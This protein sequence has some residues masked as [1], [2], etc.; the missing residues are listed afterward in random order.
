M[1][2]AHA[3]N[4]KRVRHESFSQD[5]ATLLTIIHGDVSVLYTADIPERS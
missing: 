4:Q 5:M 3:A 2:T 1:R